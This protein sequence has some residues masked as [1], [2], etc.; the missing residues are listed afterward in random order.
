MQESH[1]YYARI[2]FLLCKNHIFTMQESHFY[3]VILI[4]SFLKLVVIIP[5][6]YLFLNNHTLN[7]VGATDSEYNAKMHFI[8]HFLHKK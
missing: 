5:G 7:Q 6:L 1:F 8:Y 2:T 3:Y 4:Q